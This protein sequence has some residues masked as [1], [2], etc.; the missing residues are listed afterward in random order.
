MATDVSKEVRV[1]DPAV[2]IFHWTLAAAF[3]TAWLTGD[4]LALVHVNAGYL[5]GGLLVF[6]LIWGFVGT[7]HAR[8]SDFVRTPSQ[9]LAYVRDAVRLRSDRYVGHNPA[10]GAM[11]LALMI[12]LGITV[13]SGMA[14]Y[15]ATDFAG[16]LAGIFRGELAADLLEGLH[17]AGA[18]LT[19]FLVVL[20]L[21]GVLFSSLAEGENLIRAMITGRKERRTA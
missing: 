12:T 19:L 1:W 14:L 3:A 5:I 20:H 17:E 11:I 8:F 15:G 2:R 16:P 21:G 6:R 13:A 7:R 4:E 10:G 9:V 18:N